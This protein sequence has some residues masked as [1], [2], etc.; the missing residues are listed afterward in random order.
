M[1]R[2]TVVTSLPQPPKTEAQTPITPET[3][4]AQPGG[5]GPTNHE[6]RSLRVRVAVLTFHRPQ[7]LEALLPALVAQLVDLHAGHGEPVQGDVLV[8]DND[9][10]GT[11]RNTVQAASGE[12]VYVTEAGAGIAAGRERALAESPDVDLLAFIDDDE[13][14]CPSWLQRLVRTWSQHGSAAVAGRVLPIFEIDPSPWIRAGGFFTTRSLPTGTAVCSAATNNLL[15]DLK[16]IRQLDL[17]FERRLGL[18][19]GEDTLFTR[20]L[21][22]AGGRIVWCE[23]ACVRD[24]VPADR[25][26]RA[27]VLRRRLSHANTDTV[28]DLALSASPGGRA[29]VRLAALTSGLGLVVGGL[30]LAGLGSLSGSL[31]DQAAGMSD[32]ARGAGRL[33]GAVGAHYREYAS[34]R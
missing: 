20:T 18:S 26:T 23:E 6:N 1:N 25:V 15:L 22:R 7:Q 3:P 13:T 17:H 2:S 31:R 34:P 30:G 32:M 16:Q 33:A 8:V 27:W 29:V 12:F 24:V 19:S 5:V 21:T 4:A 9:P 28:V 14:P 11:A 10:T